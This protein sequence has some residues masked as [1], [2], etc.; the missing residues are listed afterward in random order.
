MFDSRTYDSVYPLVQDD[1]KLLDNNRKIPK[2]NGV[3]GGSIPN[4]E[5]VSLLDGKLAK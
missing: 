5:I 3:V 4:H 1:L 2:P